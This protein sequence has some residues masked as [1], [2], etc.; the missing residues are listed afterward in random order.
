MRRNDADSRGGDS[1]GTAEPSDRL[2][3]LEGDAFPA[4]VAA[5]WRRAGWTVE[6]P[7]ESE[8]GVGDG[9]ETARGT[10]VAV[11]TR[12]SNGRRKRTLLYAFPR[13]GGRVS[14]S[15]LRGV[16][17]RAESAADV[18]AV[19]PVGFAPGALDVADAHGVDVVGPDAVWRLADA[20]DAEDLLDAYA[21]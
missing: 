12:E 11:A 8:V 13:S 20:H 4:F 5:L 16:V 2:D 9:A 10:E 19:S 14:P 18:T 21:P 7:D 1:T 15:A 17:E 6:P 3:A